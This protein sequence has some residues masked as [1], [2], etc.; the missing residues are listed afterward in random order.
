MHDITLI[1]RIAYY[2]MNSG[3]G[4]IEDDLPA[5]PPIGS[6]DFDLWVEHSGD[7]YAKKFGKVRVRVES[8]EKMITE[9]VHYVGLAD[10]TKDY[11]EYLT[12]RL[13]EFARDWLETQKTYEKRL[14]LGQIGDE[15]S[16]NIDLIEER[17]LEDYRLESW[18]ELKSIIQ[19]F[20]TYCFKRGRK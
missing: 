5:D 8:I 14:E 9:G 7:N 18:D 15:E 10:N 20:E 16:Y 11:N 13:H 6:P 12:S 4:H 1:N 17:V 3:I 2:L 19:D